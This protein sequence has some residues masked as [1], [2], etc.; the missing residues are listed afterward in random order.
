MKQPL[1]YKTLTYN[2]KKG[3]LEKF[4]QLL[5][6]ENSCNV[7]QT[8]HDAS[9]GIGKVMVLFEQSGHFKESFEEMGIHA[10][11]Y[12]YENQFEKT[13]IQIDIFKEIDKFYLGEE[14]IFDDY[15]EDDLIMAFFPCT[16]FSQY[17]ETYWNKTTV[18]F[19]NLTEEEKDREIRKRL[20]ARECFFG[21]L[22]K[23]VD[24][25]KAKDIRLIVENP[26][27]QNYLLKPDVF[28]FDKAIKITDR[29]SWGGDWF[30]KP[31][32]FFFFGE[33]PHFNK[34]Y[35]KILTIE[36][37]TVM[38]CHGI[39]RSLIHTQFCKRFIKRF[40]L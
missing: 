7:Y 1:N 40:I 28:D 3:D 27:N 31:T 5:E 19:K 11:C 32:V 23:L 18:N 24:I 20:H 26:S 4:E 33:A 16:Y 25:A 14:S 38:K 6:K 15:N 13:D 36:K 22:I 12:D 21:Y 9:L 8:K 17:N 29:H 2:K 30:T 34:V 37:K 39:E 35:D 10:T